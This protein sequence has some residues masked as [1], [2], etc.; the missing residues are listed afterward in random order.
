MTQPQGLVQAMTRAGWSL[1]IAESYTCGTLT[2]RFTSAPGA[3]SILKGAAVA[4]G[5]EA[6]VRALGV[7]NGILCRRGAVSEQAARAMAQG[8][9][10]RWQTTMAVATT[11]IAGP[12]GARPLKP[13][14]LGY[15]AIAGPLG[16]TCKTLHHS[17]SR[18]AIQDAAADAALSALYDYVHRARIL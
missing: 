4:Y 10:K 12:T 5:N 16:P 7:N 17:G 11:G 6:K 9:R 13:V 2:A 8:A 14:G 1:A 18:Q 15:V 3:S